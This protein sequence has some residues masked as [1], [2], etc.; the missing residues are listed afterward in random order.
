[1]T[2]SRAKLDEPPPLLW[3]Q[4]HDSKM[5]L[6]CIL[7]GKGTRERIEELLATKCAG[8][9]IRKITTPKGW[10][11]LHCAAK[12]GHT[13]LMEWLVGMRRM[14]ILAV[15]DDGLNPLHMAALGGHLECL[16]WVHERGVGMRDA[17]YEGKNALHF[18]AEG[19]HVHLLEWFTANPNG[20]FRFKAD[21]QDAYGRH[22]LH[23]ASE[24]ANYAAITWLEEK[25][26]GEVKEKIVVKRK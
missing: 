19:G 14:D 16:L 10:N 2:S 12:M 20:L 7:A 21:V 3:S 17:T 22:A 1:M 8:L 13:K 11:A 5:I 15:A 26:V 24:H 18:A 4:V 6:D 9:D 25:K 23:F